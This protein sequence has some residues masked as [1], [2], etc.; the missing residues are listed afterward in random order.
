MNKLVTQD[1]LNKALKQMHGAEMARQRNEFSNARKICTALLKQYPDHYGALHTLGL[2]ASQKGNLDE[3]ARHLSLA[4][5]LVPSAEQTTVVLADVY[6]RMGARQSAISLLS[7]YVTEFENAPTVRFALGQAYFEE[8]QYHDALSEF[9]SVVTAMPDWKDAWWQIAHC[10]YHIGD[11][12]EAVK[13]LSD[14]CRANVRKFDALCALSEYPDAVLSKEIYEEFAKLEQPNLKPGAGTQYLFARARFRHNMGSFDEALT[15]LKT[16]NKVVAATFGDNIERN[17][18]YEDNLLNN[19]LKTARVR[20]NPKGFS[21]KTVLILGPSR[22]GKTTIEKTL[23]RIGMVTPGYETSILPTIAKQH[24]YKSGF[25]NISQYSF[26]SN[27]MFG[28]LRGEY[29]ARVLSKIESGK[30]LSI[31]APATIQDLPYLLNVFPGM[32]VIFVRRATS[33]LA[34]RIFQRDYRRGNFYAYDKTA[35]IAHIEWYWAMQDL[36]KE[37]YPEAV[38]ICHYEDFVA[39][40][41]AQID[42]MATLLDMNTGSSDCPKFG[43]D[44]GCGDPYRPFFD[45]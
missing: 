10:A 17:R 8:K 14:F 4:L 39:G 42:K 30:P 26:A 21:A 34:F 2:I 44:I 12:G 36:M 22:S 6:T 7:R 29:Q 18:Q 40:T 31:T 16:A 1:E 32:K 5:T 25:P 28:S 27:E 23:G 24:F 13:I 41:S 37:R 20:S 33:D 15:D 3:A 38:A 35:L 45:L 19:A 43:N 9:R 11:L